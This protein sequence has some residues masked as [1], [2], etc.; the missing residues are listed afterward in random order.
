MLKKLN[1]SE[2]EFDKILNQEV[3][4]FKD[5]NTSYNYIKAL[6]MPLYILNKLDLLPIGIY[7]KYFLM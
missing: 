7:E 3:K 4:S 1:V 6:K 2:D 5:Y